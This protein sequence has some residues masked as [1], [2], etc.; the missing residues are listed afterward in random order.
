MG[1]ISRSTQDRV[2]RRLLATAA[3]AFAKHGFEGANMDRITRA[4]GVAKGTVYNYFPSKERLF[5]E[6]LAE[7]ARRAVDRYTESRPLPDTRSALRA[8]AVADL[9]VLREEEDFMKVLVGEAMNPR[10]ENYPLI[11][12]HL[13]PFLAAAAEILDRGVRNGQVRADRPVPQL[14]LT[15]VGLLTLLYIQHWKSG[16]SWP[17]WDEVPDLAVGLFLDGAAGPA[18]SGSAEPPRRPR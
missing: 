6:V 7:A 10:S 11:L 9:A 12:E 3:A 16:G 14:A 17:D 4:A 8:L 1:R 5:G 2:R 13:A 18:V 15:F